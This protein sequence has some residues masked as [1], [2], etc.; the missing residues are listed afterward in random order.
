MAKFNPA[1]LVPA[2]QAPEFSKGSAART[3]QQV[4][5]D[6]I[7]RMKEQFAAG[8]A[9]EGKKNFKV[10]GEK[11]AFT[12]RVSNSAL[13]LERL[14]VQDT[15]VDVREMSVPKANFIEGLDYYADRIK[16]GEYDAQLTALTEKKEQRTTKMRAT[17]ASKKA[18]KPA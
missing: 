7:A 16:A 14:K 15:D 18:D 17:R 2:Q 1:M 12:I 11:V 5:L 4:E 6:N 10:A 8:D 13:V 3:V 9:A